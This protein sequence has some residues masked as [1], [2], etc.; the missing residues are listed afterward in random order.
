MQR[1]IVKGVC[2]RGFIWNPSN[3]ECECYK[4]CDFSKYL[5]YKICK[6]KEGFAG[7]LVQECTE[8]V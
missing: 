5:D 4:S 3:C 1:I 8:N 7:K 6:C 2:N